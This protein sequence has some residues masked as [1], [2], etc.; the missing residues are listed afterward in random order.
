MMSANSEISEQ[1]SSMP[2]SHV[3][4]ESSPPSNINRSSVWSM[5]AL[6]RS[7]VII[8]AAT[9]SA[10]CGS[11]DSSRPNCWKV[12]LSY[13]RAMEVMLCSITALSRMVCP[14][15]A[16]AFWCG[17]RLSSNMASS[18]LRN[19]CSLCILRRTLLC[20]LYLAW[21]SSWARRS[22]FTN[23]PSTRPR[24]GPVFDRIAQV[25]ALPRSSRSSSCTTLAVVEDSSQYRSAASTNFLFASMT[26]A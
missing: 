12:M 6:S 21:Q 1:I 16:V 2:L 20:A 14:S 11:R 7:S 23:R 8:A 22:S 18:L 15:P 3:L 13:M 5:E 9:F 19:I 26:L 17:I 10:L 25:T 4:N 24:W